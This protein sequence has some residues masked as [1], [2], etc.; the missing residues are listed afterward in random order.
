LVNFGVVEVFPVVD[1]FLLFCDLGTTLANLFADI[2]G[3]GCD[4]RLGEISKFPRA[5]FGL[6]TKFISSTFAKSA[7][8]ACSEY[9]LLFPLVTITIFVEF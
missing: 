9:S 3:L 7:A 4:G 6:D 8:N 1:L 5:R 2:L